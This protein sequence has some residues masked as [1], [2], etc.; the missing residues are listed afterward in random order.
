M[1]G[2]R[3]SQPATSP[4]PKTLQ[5]EFARELKKLSRSAK[6]RIEL[7][8][9]AAHRIDD[10]LISEIQS[11]L[12]QELGH[13]RARR[14][15]ERYLPIFWER[16]AAFAGRMLKKYGIE[17]RIPSSMFSIL[18]QETLDQLKNLQL[19]LVKS[20]TD[21]QKK[22]L[23]LKIREGLLAGKSVREITKDALEVVEETKWKIE[24]IVRTETARTFNLAA[25]DR[26]ERAGIK[27]W[28][29]LTALDERVCPVCS[30]RH[31]RIISDKTQLPPHGSHPNCRCTIVPY[32]PKSREK[33]P[34]PEI[35]EITGDKEL[36]E[37]ISRA[38]SDYENLLRE[39]GS[40]SRAL[41]RFIHREPISVSEAEKRGKEYIRFFGKG[42]PE[43]VRSYIQ[44]VLPYRINSKVVERAGKVKIRTTAG[45]TYKGRYYH[46]RREIQISKHYGEKERTFM[47]E[48]GHHLDHTLYLEETRK[49]FIARV[50]KHGYRL[51]MLRKHEQ[52]SHLGFD[53]FHFDG[54]D[55]IDPYAGRIYLGTYVDEH[56]KR[57]RKLVDN[58]KLIEIDPDIRNNFHT[59]LLSVGMEYFTKEELM[60][61]LWEKDRELFGFILSL[62]RGK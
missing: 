37:R 61:E 9:K 33:K 60:K 5:A 52:Y 12:E 23:A 53:I 2:D 44:N 18:D 28:R 57:L 15:I 38:L 7:M 34:E 62:L 4:I 47:H 30:S 58:P 10:S 51:E 8:L 39:E 43:D 22:K 3:I 31:G 21:E 36:D 13:E 32:L 27:R 14:F 26:Y 19:D 41:N 35:V 46:S 48:Y 20:L 29:W 42:G 16:G 55:H 1:K 17:V 6:Q 40:F 54:F 56:Y 45:R 49:F 11:V 24:R 25:A 50:K 59:E